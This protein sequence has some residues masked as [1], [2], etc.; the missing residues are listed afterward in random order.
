MKDKKSKTNHNYK[1]RTTIFTNQKMGN[2][3]K[4]I[5]NLIKW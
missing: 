4:I 5:E 1:P 3:V 2:R